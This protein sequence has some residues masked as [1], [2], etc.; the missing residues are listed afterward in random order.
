MGK[1]NGGTRSGVGGRGN[2][3]P[4][5]DEYAGYRSAETSLR[6]SYDPAKV[7]FRINDIERELG[8]EK[9]SAK[10][11]R[12]KDDFSFSSVQ[13]DNEGKFNL[14]RGDYW[15]TENMSF[16]QAVNRAVDEIKSGYRYNE[17]I[18]DHIMVVEN[19]SNSLWATIR[20]SLESDNRVSI[21]INR[22]KGL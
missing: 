6:Y 5:V 22:Y 11:L 20:A 19:D 18:R 16:A 21:M 7:K 8:I 12:T 13:R 17:N 15:F 10:D 14:G 9:I 4:P 3:N 2:V 1:G